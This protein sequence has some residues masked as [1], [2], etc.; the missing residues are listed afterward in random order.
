MSG[1]AKLQE[2]VAW[3]AGPCCSQRRSSRLTGALVLDDSIVAVLLVVLQGQQLN[4]SSTRCHSMLV[5][6]LTQRQCGA[7]KQPAA[8]ALHTSLS[9]Q[10]CRKQ[11]TQ[12]TAGT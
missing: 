11:E 5:L 9:S 1:N 7:K 6:L 10:Y 8:V 3:A 4:G 12:Q 2:A